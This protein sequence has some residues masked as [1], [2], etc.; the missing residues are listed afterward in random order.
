MVCSS[1]ITE[2][3]NKGAA[4][5]PDVGILLGGISLLGARGAETD[6]RPVTFLRDLGPQRSVYHGRVCLA[7]SADDGEAGDEVTIREDDGPYGY[8]LGAM[9]C[10]LIFADNL[11]RR[12]EDMRR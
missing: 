9:L 6:D 8:Q 12:I 1:T 5:V 10:F 4:A 2:R 3:R 7:F 11:L